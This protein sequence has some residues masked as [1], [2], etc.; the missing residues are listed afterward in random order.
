MKL[1]SV[2][3]PEAYVEAMDELVR[4]GDYSSRTEVGRVAVG[5]LVEKEK[6]LPP[7]GLRSHSLQHGSVALNNKPHAPRL[8]DS[9]EDIYWY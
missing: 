7:L 6:D 2:H 3:L 1:V 9:E 4:R 5:K 8:P